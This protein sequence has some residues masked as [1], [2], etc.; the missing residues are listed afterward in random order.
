MAGGIDNLDNVFF[1]WAIGGGG[2]DGDAS[3]FFLGHPIH[4]SGAFVNVSELVGFACVVE[5]TLGGGGF[6]CIDMG[7]NSDIA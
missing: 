7:H 2:G 3:F 4:G 5:D 6:A 1:P